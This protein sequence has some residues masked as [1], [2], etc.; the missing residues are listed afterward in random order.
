MQPEGEVLHCPI[1]A[2]QYYVLQLSLSLDIA[3]LAEQHQEILVPDEGAH[4]D[5]LVEINLEEVR[6]YHGCLYL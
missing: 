6:L 1:K 3:S 2:L 4:Y 5:R